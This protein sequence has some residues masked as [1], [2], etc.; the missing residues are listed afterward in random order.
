M[1]HR[2]RLGTLTVAERLVFG[3][4]GTSHA[5][6]VLDDGSVT[7]D[8][9]RLVVSPEP[10][11]STAVTDGD[12]T[13]RAWT[14]A[15]G[16]EVW[17]QYDGCV[18]VLTRESGSWAAAGGRHQDRLAAPMPASVLQVLVEPGAHVS[19]GDVLIL[20]EA[21]KME[22]PVRAGA[23]GTVRAVRCQAGD[24]VQ[25]GVPLVDLDED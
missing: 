19:R 25:P 7:V 22:L 18:Y 15:V 2:D 3:H 23:D 10:G 1:D 16:D 11:G 9:R 20:L 12:R 17:V 13:T 24:L 6:D 5:A 8:G 21:M 4:A 14:A